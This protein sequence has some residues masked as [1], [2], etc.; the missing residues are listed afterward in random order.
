M[1]V[2]IIP[3]QGNPGTTFAVSLSDAWQDLA[4]LYMNDAN[5]QTI[6]M[7]A[8][9]GN[10]P[11]VAIAVLLSAVTNGAQIA[12]SKQM[13]DFAGHPLNANDTQRYAGTD[14]IKNAWVK[15]L[16]AGSVAVLIITPEFQ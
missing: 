5:A 13:P 14:W 3:Q 8:G 7:S 16:T 12:F 4:V 9:P 10:P 6:Q 1:S 11:N 15:N 2:S